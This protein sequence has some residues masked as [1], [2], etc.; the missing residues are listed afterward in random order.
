LAETQ[1]EKTIGIDRNATKPDIRPHDTVDRTPG[2]GSASG[3]PGIGPGIEDNIVET[4][5]EVNP[6]TKG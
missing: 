4:I 5:D 1:E 3:G 6:K 2:D